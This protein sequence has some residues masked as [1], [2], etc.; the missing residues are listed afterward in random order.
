MRP[1]RARHTCTPRF[2]FSFEQLP[3][4]AQSSICSQASTPEQP[5]HVLLASVSKSWAAAVTRLLQVDE[6]SIEK[7]LVCACGVTADWSSYVSA[8]GARQLDSLSTWLCTN[9]RAVTTLVINTLCTS[10]GAW[11]EASGWVDGVCSIL[12]VLGAGQQPLGGLPLQRLCLPAVG[13]TPPTMIRRALAAC[14][15]L[16]ELH[17]DARHEPQGIR[18]PKTYL[19]QVCECQ[20]GEE[21]TAST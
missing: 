7:H 12:Q 3:D 19:E 16:R 4:E 15:N 9:R 1:R 14:P 8:I 20:S 11:K 17:L 5:G 13:G 6:I 21:S 2:S 10:S 18:L